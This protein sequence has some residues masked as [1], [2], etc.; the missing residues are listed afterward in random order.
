MFNINMRLLGTVEP[1]VGG[2]QTEREQHVTSSGKHL[3]EATHMWCGGADINP[4]K[5]LVHLYNVC[6]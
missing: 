2:T 5:L 3:Q 4:L 1:H 6:T